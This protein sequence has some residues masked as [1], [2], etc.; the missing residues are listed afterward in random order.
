MLSLPTMGGSMYPTIHDGD[1]VEVHRHRSPGGGDLVV[2]IRRNALVAHRVVK[3]HGERLW[4]R[5]DNQG[6]PSEEVPLRAVVGPI[7]RILREDG[8]VVERDSPGQMLG[9]RAWV[10]APRVMR[11]VSRLWNLP[12]RARRLLARPVP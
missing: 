10:R 11:L 7:S 12:W 4:T 8:S 9:D 2:Y 1:Q 3:M 5:G 6:D